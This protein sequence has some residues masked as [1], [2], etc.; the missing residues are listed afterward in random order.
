M[1]HGL[2]TAGGAVRKTEFMEYFSWQPRSVDFGAGVLD[3]LGPL[4][5]CGDESAQ[6]DRRACKHRV[7]EV[8]DSR[9][10][11]GISETRI[12]LLVERV[13]DLDGRVPGST[14]PCPTDRL[15][16]RYEFAHSW[17]VWQDLH[18]RCGGHCQRAQFARPDVPD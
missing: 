2:T 1:A 11:A 18:P 7:T 16:A 14:D 10:D 8:G 15:V 12:D 3:H 13:D 6:V 5:I 9:L 17:N 4:L